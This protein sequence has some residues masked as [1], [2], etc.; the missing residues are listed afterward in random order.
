MGKRQITLE[1]AQ[2]RLAQEND[3]KW[4]KDRAATLRDEA[5]ED[6]ER[7]EQRIAALVSELRGGPVKRTKRKSGKPKAEATTS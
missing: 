3:I 7:G 6:G 4:A 5:H 1:Q 2:E